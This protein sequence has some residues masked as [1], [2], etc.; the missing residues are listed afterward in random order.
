MQVCV[1]KYTETSIGYPL[2]SLTRR[3][4]ELILSKVNSVTYSQCDLKSCDNLLDERMSLI[5]ACYSKLVIYIWLMFVSFALI[6][7]LQINQKVH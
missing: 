4:I 3:E 6:I 7:F 1:H 2:S 5:G